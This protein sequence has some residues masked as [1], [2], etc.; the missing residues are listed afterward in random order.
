MC[1]NVVGDYVSLWV[2]L[3]NLFHILFIFVYWLYLFDFY[4][5]MGMDALVFLHRFLHLVNQNR[6]HTF[7]V[8]QVIH[9]L[10]LLRFDLFLS[11]FLIFCLFL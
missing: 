6:I 4:F 7:C 5:P 10:C 11:F 9:F 3:E 1:S 8:D 2:M